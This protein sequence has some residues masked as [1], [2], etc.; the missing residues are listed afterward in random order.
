MRGGGGLH[1]IKRR[2]PF[3]RVFCAFGDSRVA[4]L[5]FHCPSPCHI[6]VR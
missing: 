5:L 2:S 4:P 1:A 3:D 6:L